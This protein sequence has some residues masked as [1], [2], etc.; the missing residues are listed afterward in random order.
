MGIVIHWE[1]R[2]QHV[3]KIKQSVRKEEAKFFITFKFTRLLYPED[4]FK[5]KR[6]NSSNRVVTF[7]KCGSR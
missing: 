1:L 7:F 5:Y 2:K 4:K 3:K 6:G